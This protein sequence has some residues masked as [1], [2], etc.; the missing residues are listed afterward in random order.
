[1]IVDKKDPWQFQFL[2][3]AIESMT[4]NRFVEYCLRFQFLYGAI[5]SIASD[6]FGETV[7]DFNSY[8]V[9]LRVLS[10]GIMSLYQI[11]SIPIWCD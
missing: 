2:Y 1:M 4:F 5:E 10:V 8:M 11:I 7:P 3:G 9:R 6:T